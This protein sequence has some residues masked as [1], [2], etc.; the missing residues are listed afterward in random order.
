MPPKTD[1]GG[2]SVQLFLPVVKLAHDGTC[3]MYKL[4]CMDFAA[5]YARA[6]AEYTKCYAFAAR[7][8]RAYK[9]TMHAA[10]CD[11]GRAPVPKLISAPRRHAVF[12][13]GGR[14]LS[15]RYVPNVV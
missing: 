6:W 9:R 13:N 14:L 4:L 8:A 2:T 10:T 3:S 5:R 12:V 7:Y 15:W 11:G 1:G